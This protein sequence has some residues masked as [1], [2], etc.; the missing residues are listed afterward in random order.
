MSTLLFLLPFLSCFN[1]NICNLL[2]FQVFVS[3]QS[4]FPLT[5]DLYIEGRTSG[6][7]P[8]DDEDGEEDFSGSGSGDYSKANVFDL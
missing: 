8:L 3:S 5:D 4:S 2:L 6:D 1:C 7:F